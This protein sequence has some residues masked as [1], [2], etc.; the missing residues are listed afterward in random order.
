[1]ILGKYKIESKLKHFQ[2]ITIPPRAKT[3]SPLNA[4]CSHLSLEGR[5]PHRILQAFF[6]L[7]QWCIPITH[8]DLHFVP[9]GKHLADL[10]EGLVLGLWNH[11]PD[12]D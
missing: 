2:S 6:A 10:Q 3:S 5:D 7:F 8:F 12:V 1:M 11:Q 4:E 9:L